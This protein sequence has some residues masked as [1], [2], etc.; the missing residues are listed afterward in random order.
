MTD[1]YVGRMGG[2]PTSLEQQD[3][4]SRF[5]DGLPRVPVK[6][7]LDPSSVEH[8]RALF[9]AHG[10]IGCHVN[11]TGTL[12]FDRSIGKKD[13]QGNEMQTQVPM[14][15][16]VADRAPYMHDGCAATL[17]DRFTNVACAGSTHGDTASLSANDIADMVTFLESL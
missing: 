8:G 10:C 5:L 7:H 2:L 14:L 1:V 16:G 13:E 12:T 15:L 11:E 9:H 4:L 6:A 3:A 17:T